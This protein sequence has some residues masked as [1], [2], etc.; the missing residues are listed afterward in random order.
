MRSS[1]ALVLIVCALALPSSA[2]AQQAG[3]KPAQ[4]QAP[5]GTS[6]QAQ[7]RT[8]QKPGI[9]RYLTDAEGRSLYLF[10]ADSENRSACY[11]ACAQAWPPLISRAAP[12]AGEGVQQELLGTLRR[13]D[14]TEQV[15]YNGWPL[16]YFVKDAQPGQTEGQDVEGFGEEWYLVT[17]AGEVAHGEAEQPARG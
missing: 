4:R 15:T 1:P 13:K 9:G 6:D 7:I 11:D 16:Y 2:L 12:K 5:E 10:M 17:P 14:G 8:D 3:Q